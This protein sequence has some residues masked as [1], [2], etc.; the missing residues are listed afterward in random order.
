[1][2]QGTNLFD[3]VTPRAE[4]LAGELTEGM[5]AASLENVASGHRL[6][7]YADAPTFF[8]ATHPSG[9]LRTLLNVALG[10]LC[11]DRSAPASILRL[12]TSLG[13]GKTHNLIALYYAAR[14]QLPAALAPE[15][16]DPDLLPSE[17]VSVGVFVGTS[18][19][20][21]SFP[22]VA[23]IAARTLWG[24]LALQLGG[25]EGYDLVAEDDRTQTPPGSE[26]LR[27]LLGD[28]PTLLLVDEIAR[29][30]RIASGIAVGTS[31]L[32]RQTTAFLMALMEAVD[33]SP[34]AVLVLT[35]TATTDAFG[36]ETAVVLA[37]LAEAQSLFAR[38]EMVLRPS[39][40]ADLPRILSR[41]LFS[42]V[43]DGVSTAVGAAYGETA[44]AARAG[45]LELPESMT[46]VG[47]FGGQVA[48]HYPF[49][50]SLIAVLDKRLSTIPNFQ[51][52]RG[53][54]RLLARAVRRLWQERPEGTQAIHLHHIDLSDAA[55][56]EELSSRIDRTTFEQVIRSD[57]AS[58]P[59]GS[60][61]HAEEVDAQMGAP[62]GRQ[63]A[64][65]IYLY[66]LTRDTPGI[67]AAMAYAAVLAPGTD[68]NVLQRALHR[69]D[70]SCWYLH[71]ADLRGLRFST[72]PSLVKLIQQAEAGITPGKVAERATQILSEQYKDGVFKV[73]RSWLQAPVP[74]NAEDLWLV[75][76]HWDDFGDAHGV[77]PRAG[78]P[79]QICDLWEHTI[80]GG[81]RN[82]RNRLVIAAPNTVGHASMLG[83]VRQH[84]A[85]LAVNSSADQLSGLGSDKVKE[86]AER[87]KTSEL[88][89]RVA[90]C[91]HVNVLYVP[92]QADLEVVE[93]PAVSTASVPRNQGDSVVEQLAS[94][95]KLLRGGD[96]VLDPGFVKDKLGALLEQR[97]PTSELIRVF[98]R[99][100]DLPMVL[101]RDQLVS[102]VSAGVRSGAWEYHDAE[103]GD[104][105]WAT[106]EHPSAAYHLGE[107]TFLAP[108]GS[109]PPPVPLTCPFCATVHPGTSCPAPAASGAA[110]P[111]SSSLVGVG[112]AATSARYPGVGSLGTPPLGEQP[113]SLAPHGSASKCPSD[114]R[115]QGATGDALAQVRS[116]AV[117]AER[118]T[119]RRLDAE[120]ERQGVDLGKDLARLASVVAAS[121]PGTSITYDFSVE[122]DASAPCEVFL[123]YRG[124]PADY[125]PLRDAVRQ[126]LANRTAR[127]HASV[128]VLF[129]PPLDLSGDTLARL[130]QSAKD[131]GPNP[132]TV[133]IVTEGDDDQG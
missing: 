87:A 81:M 37:E 56:A 55:I 28:R 130:A 98:A 29:Y 107:D 19:G 11:G 2:S 99:R 22:P 115:A 35:T 78:V 52:T 113:M 73:R 54:L 82:Y 103:R 104:N 90:V 58:Q 86:V 48:S 12:E 84:L 116:A 95:G 131:T 13:G 34:R 118:S 32:A 46:G 125:A 128:E 21:Q 114:F 85:L 100:T 43:A 47:G 40:E 15:F 117:A 68:V 31:T 72:E 97:Q 105:G 42:S 92:R 20:A 96:P 71:N 89:A 4:V 10:R 119:V 24:Y 102:L 112:E 44:D 14:G 70:S 127:V 18:A 5:F 63:L 30:Y 16:C 6:G 17:P 77:D 51:R 62:Y 108:V 121:T 67:T 129:N 39:E 83:A 74:D 91:N 7:A 122:V 109:A 33:A 53:A 1:M 75:I 50:P 61:S 8:A 120:I 133:R 94:L 26:A 9:G 88:T 23:G 36:D 25:V 69:L 41:R 124:V 123:H 126:V 79:D 110:T 66:S 111:P 27:R 80:S 64:T 38:K 101:D 49:H 132:C 3:H 60:S 93:L 106:A 65:T 76:M 59:G 45:G 57:I